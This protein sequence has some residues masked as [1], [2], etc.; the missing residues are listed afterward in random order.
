MAPARVELGTS[1]GWW[2]GGR[3]L[4]PVLICCFLWHGAKGSPNKAL[5]FVQHIIEK[6]D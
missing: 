6:Q 2:E 3:A 1:Q 4:D 5:L